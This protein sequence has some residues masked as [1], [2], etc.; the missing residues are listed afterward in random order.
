[1]KASLPAMLAAIVASASAADEAN[2][3]YYVSPTGNDGNPGTSIQAPLR[4]IQQAVVKAMPGSTILV[5]AGV[6]RETVTT[7]RSGTAMAPITI[8]NYHDEVVTVSGAD[9]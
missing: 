3:V 4:T 5:R 9:V 6:Y 1:M 7:L 8:Q 2:A